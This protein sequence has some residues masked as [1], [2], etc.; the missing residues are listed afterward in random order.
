M[1]VGM[2]Q[3]AKQKRQKAERTGRRAECL[4]AALLTLKGF[5][6]LARRV[7]NPAGEIDLVAR[8]GGL[9]VFVEVK[10]RRRFDDAI[11]AVGPRNRSRVSAAA[12]MY[13][14]RRPQLAECMR[15]YDIIAVAGWRLRHI[16]D[17]W[18]DRGYVN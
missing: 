3:K 16:P 5:A 10:A 11:E 4:A 13:V 9:L 12:N 6:I 17:A 1:T 14:S 15:R 8:R 2:A 18:R 7:K